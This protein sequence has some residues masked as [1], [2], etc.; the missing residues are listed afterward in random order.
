[1]WK[2]VEYTE[3]TTKVLLNFSLFNCIGNNAFLNETAT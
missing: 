3:V 1:M 2:P